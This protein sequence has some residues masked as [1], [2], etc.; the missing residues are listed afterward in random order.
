MTV[1]FHRLSDIVEHRARVSPD[2]LAFRYLPDG[3]ISGAEQLRSYA[4]L[5]DR[6]SRLAWVLTQVATRGERVLL[7][8]PPGLGF[9]DCFLACERAGLVVVPVPPV[10]PK[11]ARRYAPRLQQIFADAKPNVVVASPGQTRALR[12][13]INVTDEVKWIA[14]EPGEQRLESPVNRQARDPLVIQYTSGSTSKPKGVVLSSSA[15]M[16]NLAQIDA[17]FP[18][19]PRAH[20]IS[21]LPQFHDFGLFW[22]TLSPLYSGHPCSFFPP[23]AFI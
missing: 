20:H 8:L 1:D 19:E 13:L 3:T 12:G 23:M 10:E 11:L 14:P 2:Q 5:F 15:I 6:T 18:H 16:A 9:I 7:L 21:W 4:E 17:G 22:A